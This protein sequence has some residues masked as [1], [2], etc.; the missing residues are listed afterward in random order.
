MIPDIAE[1]RSE[2]RFPVVIPVEYFPPDASGILSYAFNLSSNGTF[3]SSDYPL[4]VGSR[5]AIHLIIPV[6]CESCSILR[7][8]G[9]VVWNKIQ[10]FRTRRNGMG[11]RFIEPLPEAL[12]L[13]ALAN[14]VQRLTRETEAKELL[15][16]RV[17]KLESELKETKRLADLGRCVERI[18]FEASNPILTLSGQLEII[19]MKMDEHKRILEKPEINKEKV[20]KI[21]AEF[22]KSCKEIERILK[23][24]RIISE[25]AAIAGDDREALERKL[26]KKYEG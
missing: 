20:R 24:Y 14:N 12:L 22:D 2:C 3:V 25:L 17:G 13:N 21:I 9:T 6:D 5:F 18:L 8:E 1:R 4:R 16:E 7:T 23:D 10:P 15:E 11:V 19:K 26:K